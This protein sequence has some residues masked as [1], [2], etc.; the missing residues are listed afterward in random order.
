MVIDMSQLAGKMA[1]PLFSEKTLS[2]CHPQC[3]PK[4]C[5]YLI[6][7]ERVCLQLNQIKNLMSN[8]PT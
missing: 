1:T 5:C 6:F 7:L 8:L 2:I 3:Y 4:C